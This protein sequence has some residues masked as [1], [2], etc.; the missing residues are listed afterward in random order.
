MN[1]PKR[2]QTIQALDDEHD[3]VARI[4]ATCPTCRQPPAEGSHCRSDCQYGE[5][6]GAAI[7]R[8]LSQLVF[9]T[10]A[11]FDHEVDVLRANVSREDFESHSKEH[12]R[13][14]GAL[15]A[16]LGEYTETRDCLEAIRKVK[17]F[18]QAILAHMAATDTPMLRTRP[19]TG[20]L[21]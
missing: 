17:E 3:S 21:Q 18:S 2:E 9:A 7:R 14:T 11:H 8:T 5:A 13:L 1:Q 10:V 19:P 4:L 12:V 20:L 15:T 16:I 6:C